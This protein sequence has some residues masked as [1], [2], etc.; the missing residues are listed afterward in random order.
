MRLMRIQ[1]KEMVIVVVVVAV[2]GKLAPFTALPVMP[3]PAVAVVAA[4]INGLT[5]KSGTVTSQDAPVVVWRRENNLFVRNN[6]YHNTKILV[7]LLT[8]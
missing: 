6:Q 1:G 5:V 2:V 7:K 8:K 4:A 3:L